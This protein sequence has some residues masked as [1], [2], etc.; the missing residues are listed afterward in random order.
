MGLNENCGNRVATGINEY[1]NRK[2][3]FGTDR[4]GL[5]TVT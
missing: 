5:R 4:V 2:K 1:K 3:K